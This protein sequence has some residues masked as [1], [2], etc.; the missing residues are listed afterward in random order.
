M[1]NSDI[2]VMWAIKVTVNLSFKLLIAW[3]VYSFL[4]WLSAPQW[5]V[6]A[7][8]AYFFMET[9]FDLEFKKRMK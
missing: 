8:T 5:I 7:L 2:F 4:I 3:L 6:I 1:N 9:K